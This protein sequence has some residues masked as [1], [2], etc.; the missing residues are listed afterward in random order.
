MASSPTV[1]GSGTEEMGRAGAVTSPLGMATGNVGRDL[2]TCRH[3]SFDNPPCSFAVGDIVD[4]H[5]GPVSSEFCANRR[6]D[7]TR[8]ARDYCYFAAQP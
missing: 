3:D 4:E 6:A 7:S 1:A 8:S 5:L 2:A